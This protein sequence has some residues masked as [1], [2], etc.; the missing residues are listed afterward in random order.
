MAGFNQLIAERFPRFLKEENPEVILVAG[1]D[2]AMHHVTKKFP[3]YQ[4]IYLGKG[5]GTLNFL[6][7]E[8]ADDIGTLEKLQQ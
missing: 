1:G 2:G 3:H 5:L 7:N 6:M 8:I 4:G